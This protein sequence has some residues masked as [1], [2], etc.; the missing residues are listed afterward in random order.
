MKGERTMMNCREATHEELKHMYRERVIEIQ[1]LKN[2]LDELEN[3]PAEDVAELD[4][5]R[6]YHKLANKLRKQ[7]IIIDALI[8]KVANNE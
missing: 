5:K 6:E 7:E 3:Q 4:Y 1:Q 2:R 8:D